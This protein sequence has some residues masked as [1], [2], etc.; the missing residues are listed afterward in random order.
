MWT[1][2]PLHG[3]FARRFDGEI[4]GIILSAHF[5]VSFKSLKWEHQQKTRR[6]ISASSDV[7]WLISDAVKSSGWKR[8]ECNVW[9]HEQQSCETCSFKHPSACCCP[10]RSSL[11]VWT[12]A[13][14]G[15]DSWHIGRHRQGNTAADKTGVVISSAFP[16]DTLHETWS[17][18]ILTL[19]HADFGRL[20]FCCPLLSCSNSSASPHVLHKRTTFTLKGFSG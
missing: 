12:P 20:V 5:Q 18:R 10:E 4:N 17:N 9:K 11:L 19:P 16:S 3:R 15:T 6:L 7:G 1:S 14:P 8:K 13:S 2:P